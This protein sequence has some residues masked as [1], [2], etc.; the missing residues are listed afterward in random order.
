MKYNF[1]QSVVQDTYSLKWKDSRADGKYAGCI[2][3]WVADMDYAVAPEITEALSK[4]AAIPVYGYTDMSQ[5][6]SAAI[7]NWMKQKHQAQIEP[8]WILPVPGVVPAINT[9]LLAMLKEGS[10]VLLHTPIYHP[11]Y[12]SIENNHC[13]VVTSSLKMDGDAIEIDFE[14][15]EKKLQEVEAFIL[16]NPHNP[17]GKI[18]TKEE[19]AR[20]AKLCSK[21]NVLLIVDEIH[22][23]IVSLETEFTT[24]FNVPEVDRSN[25]IFTSAPSKTFNIAGLAASHFIIPD[26][27]VRQKV[28]QMQQQ[29]GAKSLSLFAE[30]GSVAA[31]ENGCA[32]NEAC[33]QYIEENRNEGLA[34]IEKNMPQLRVIRPEGTYFLWIDCRALNIPADRLFDFFVENAKIQF[35][36]GEQFGVE[37]QGYVRMNIACTRQTLLQALKQM[38]VAIDNQ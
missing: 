9:S 32:W 2:P 37:G 23:D 15:F 38:K 1:D 12:A 31:Y 26:P 33:V 35:S 16:C 24:I 14:D 13:Q 28:R 4:R 10:R 18:Y 20:I 27:I 11:F 21:Y 22:Q 7:V 30:V 8:E 36:P 17:T 29:T 19:L 34:F 5:R 6:F 3:M 25:M